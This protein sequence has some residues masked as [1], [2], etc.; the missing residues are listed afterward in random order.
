V[1][2]TTDTAANGF[3]L[4]ANSPSSAAVL[5]HVGEALLAAAERVGAESQIQGGG[6]FGVGAC[7]WPGRYR[8]S[9]E[10][11]VAPVSQPR[12]ACGVRQGLIA[13]ELNQ[14]LEM[15]IPNA[16]TIR[17]GWRDTRLSSLCPVGCG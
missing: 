6:Q 13:L 17:P 1:Q 16:A 15:S 4:T 8:R 12:N 9:G 2:I 10:P 7:R 14:P 3:P 11:G 5:L